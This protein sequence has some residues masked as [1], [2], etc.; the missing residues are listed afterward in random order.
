MESLPEQVLPQIIAHSLGRPSV[1]HAFRRAFLAVFCSSE[2]CV[3][4]A[5]EKTR[6]SYAAA[7]DWLVRQ[8][9][10]L[11]PPAN[12]DACTTLLTHKAPADQLDPLLHTA[13]EYGRTA[14]VQELLQRGAD[15]HAE[16]DIAVCAAAAR[17]HTATVQALLAAGADVHAQQG[18][19]L[20]E[21]AQGGHNATVQV[22]LAAGA[23][24]HAQQDRAL[25][26]AAQGGHTAIVQALLAAGADVHAQQ[27][28]ALCEAAAGGHTTT[29][30]ALLAAGADARVLG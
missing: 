19:A 3:V 28:E 9:N 1:S 27:D 22:L 11:Q 25:C 23:G 4:W 12:I 21:A 6:G 30:Q 20:C 15:V 14:T 26:E 5:L 18:E 24:V 10:Q 16:Q 2:L 8:Q 29:V 17:G 13:A 7:Y